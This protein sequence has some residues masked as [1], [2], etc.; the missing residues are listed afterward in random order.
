MY[1]GQPIYQVAGPKVFPSET[2]FRIAVYRESY[3]INVRIWP[4]KMNS[5]V[6]LT[7]VSNGA[8]FPHQF[9]TATPGKVIAKKM[10]IVA[11]MSPVSRAAAVT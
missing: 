8:V 3:C 2:V 10:T 9:G 5:Q 11:R 4:P 7:M 6:A 1:P